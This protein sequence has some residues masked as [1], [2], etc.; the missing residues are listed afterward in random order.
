VIAAYFI[1]EASVR[2]FT[3]LTSIITIFAGAQLLTL[4]TLGEYLAR[5][6]VRLMDR[7]VYIVRTTIGVGSGEPLPAVGERVGESS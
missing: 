4:G 1:G 3:F 7:P 6:H 2:G 5:M